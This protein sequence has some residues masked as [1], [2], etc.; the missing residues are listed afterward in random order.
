[1]NLGEDQFGFRQ[2]MGT[3]S[4]LSFENDCRK[5]AKQKYIYRVY[6]FRKAF[7]TVNWNLLMT[8]LKRARLDWRDRKIIMELYSYN[9]LKIKKQ[10]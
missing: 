7:N 1:M 5:K 8:T 2:G 9:E 10:Q 6:R 4:Y 3:R